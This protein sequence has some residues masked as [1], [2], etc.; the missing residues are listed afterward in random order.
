VGRLVP[1]ARLVVPASAVR[2]L[3]R[4]VER[5]SPGA[6]TARALADRYAIVATRSEGDDA[7]AEVARRKRA[8]V[9]TADR[10]LQSRLTSLGVG[11]LAP[12]D[13]HRLE[14]RLP[15]AVSAPATSRTRGGRR[16]RGNR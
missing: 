4:L 13:R 12:R 1:G 6:V 8:W 5:R 16:P 9:V 2:E 7:V 10:A 11:V 15:V 14:A 3:D